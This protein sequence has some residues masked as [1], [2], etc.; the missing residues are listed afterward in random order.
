VDVESLWSDI[1]YGARRLVQAPGFASVAILTLALGIG[2][3]TAI[4]SLIDAMLLRP[5][6]YPAPER[7]VF[8]TEWSEQVPDMSFSVANF[9]DVRDQSRSF[10]ELGA[11]RSESFT[12]TGLGE[13]ER[14]DGRQASAGFLPALGLEP[15]IGRFPTPEEDRPGAERVAVLSEGLWARRFGRDRGVLGQA[16]TLSGESY[17]VIGVAP[18]RFHTSWQRVDLF[19]PLLQLEDRLGGAER[20]GSHPGIYVVGRL[21]GGAS[22]EAART[23][24]VSIAKRLA[25]QYPESSA[26]QSMTLEPLTSVVVGDTRGALLVLLGAVAMVLL[27]ACANVANLLL[28]RGAARRRELAL[29]TALGASRRRVA[30]QLLTESLLLSLAGG[31][32]GL[33]LAELTLRGLLTLIPEAAAGVE[34]V[35]LHPAILAFTALLSLATGVLFGLAP[36][37]QAARQDPHDALKEGGRGI[38]GGGYRLR[39][40]LVVAEMALSVL[41]L[42]G[43]GVLLRSF[44]RVIEADPGFDPEGVV[45]ATLRLPAVGYEEK[46][47]ITLFARQVLER[48]QALPGVSSAAATLP[49]LGGWQTSFYVE[50]SPPPAPGEQPSTDITRVSGEYFETMRVPLQ[51]GRL[52]DERD[53]AE[54]PPVCI[55]DTTFA[56]AWWPGEDPLGKRLKPGGADSD[57][58][59]LEVVG[60]VGHV[61]NYGVDQDSRVETYVPYDQNPVPGFNLVVRGAGAGPSLSEGLREAVRAVDPT[62]PL[63]DVRRLEDVVSDSQSDRRIAALLVGSFAALAL[64]LAAVGLYGVVSYSVSQQTGEIGVRLALGAARRDILKLVVGR[65]MLLAVIGVGLGLLG[66]LALSR[67]MGAVLFEVSPTDPATYSASPLLLSLIA[68]AACY[69]PA[70]RAMRIEPSAVLRDE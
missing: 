16:L 67:V 66:A 30:R 28:A 32:L 37:W 14:L 26:R 43:A 40:G 29:R 36:A 8:L 18:A 31:G 41:L 45:T 35:R 62:I 70:R 20:R 22:V 25:E 60:V 9:K 57:A 19:T 5:L 61:K 46:G 53:S 2:L 47:R 68:L 55:V 11:F 38:Q 33:L 50:G 15:L 56:Q 21:E 23:E 4:F 49:L 54:A 51:R 10:S 39:Q 24:V 1:R 13:A 69:L 52:F 3:N 64:L 42:V 6:P 48:V 65:G 34:Q 63:Y 44:Q 59:W 17:T 27:I 12:L 58:P 7:L